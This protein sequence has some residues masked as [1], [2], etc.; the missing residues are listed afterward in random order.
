MR[1]ESNSCENG[2]L[3]MVV[4]EKILVMA[5]LTNEKRFKNM[6]SGQG[7]TVNLE[8]YVNRLTAVFMVR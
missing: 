5:S 6:V 2:S 4:W 7:S 1:V 8:Y 3:D